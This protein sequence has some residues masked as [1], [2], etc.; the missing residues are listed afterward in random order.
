MDLGVG[1][2]GAGVVGDGGSDR[3]GDRAAAI[4][5]H[6]PGTSFLL[7]DSRQEKVLGQH[8]LSY[9]LF[10]SHERMV[11]DLLREIVG[12]RWVERIDL[13]SAKRVS[14]SFVS[15]Q[16]KGRE[17][18]VIW[19]FRTL[20]GQAPVYVYI[21][22]EFQSRPDRYMAVR[23]MAYEGLLY[24]ALIAGSELSS[25]GRLPLVIPIVVY[26]GRGPWGVPQELSELIEPMDPS[27]EMY[28]PRLRYKLVDEGSYPREELERRESPV[29]SLF[30][31]EKSRSWDDVLSSVSRLRQHLRPDEDSLREAF[32]VW[33]RRVVLPRSGASLEGI[34]A[35]LTL[36]DFE[37]MLAE[38]IDEWNRKLREESLEQ[39]V[40]QGEARLLLRQLR[41]KFGPLGPETEERV[42]SAA[43]DFLEKWSDRLFSAKNLDEIFGD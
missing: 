35:T 33:L 34:S 1:G 39:G 27:A 43:P 13:S 24:Q 42:R 28:L 2:G 14:T 26:N 3:G 41:L 5:E 16:L 32:E 37:T 9:R 21:L 12:E 25:Q 10:F 15:R 18:D 20:D 31:I 8:D 19:K 30:Q 29:A 17:S 4:E 23:L 7:L 38:N 36:E 11:C 22:M 6:L 40:Q